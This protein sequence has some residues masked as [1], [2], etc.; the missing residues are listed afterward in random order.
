MNSHNGVILGLHAQKSFHLPLARCSAIVILEM[1]YTASEPSSMS[2]K[3][4]S[5]YLRMPIR[6][7]AQT[8]SMPEAG[9]TSGIVVGIWQTAVDIIREI[10]LARPVVRR[11]LPYGRLLGRAIYLL[12]FENGE[13][14]SFVDSTIIL[15]PFSS[16]TS[17]FFF[18][19]SFVLFLYVS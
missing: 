2:L 16:S 1:R 4:K 17:I 8:L 7:S 10:T 12:F 3:S 5:C 13:M 18:F 19:S 6:F 14:V 15:S 11:S 9:I